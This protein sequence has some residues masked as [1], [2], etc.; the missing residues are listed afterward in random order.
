MA[1]PELCTGG[2]VKSYLKIK[3]IFTFGRLV[4]AVM[5]KKVANTEESRLSH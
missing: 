2:K 1:F 5:S 4:L 3:N